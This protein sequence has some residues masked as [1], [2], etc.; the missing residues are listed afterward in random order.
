MLA[1]NSN[2]V[3]LCVLRFLS[4]LSSRALAQHSVT[5]T[6]NFSTRARPAP[7]ASTT[8]PARKA[9]RVPHFPHPPRKCGYLQPAQDS[10]T[11]TAEEPASLGPRNPRRTL[12]LRLQKSQLPCSGVLQWWAYSSLMSTPSARI[13]LLTSD[14]FG[15]WCS[16]TVNVDNGKTRWVILC[17]KKQEWIHSNAAASTSLKNLNQ[18]TLMQPTFHTV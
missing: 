17:E 13:W 10:S 18:A 14:M 6:K 4:W 3:H 11:L 9:V 16:A 15:R 1:N 7:A 8:R 12:A 5:R 2:T